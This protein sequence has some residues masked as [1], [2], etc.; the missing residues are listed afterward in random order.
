MFDSPHL[1][2]LSGVGPYTLGLINGHRAKAKG[3]VIPT[4][5]IETI[6]DLKVT[7]Y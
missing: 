3:I 4:D 6:V 7:A 2:L 5:A 1:L